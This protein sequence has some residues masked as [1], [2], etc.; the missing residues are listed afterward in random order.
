MNRVMIS[1]QAETVAALLPKLMRT[2][3]AGGDDAAARLPL[4]QLRVCGVLCDGPQPMSVVSRELGVSLPA[5]TQIADRLERVRLVERVS[6]G[7]DRRVRCLQLTDRGE[8]M[9]R[10][11]EQSRVAS[12]LAA[13][14][15]LTPGRRKAVVDML[16]LLIEAG[17]VVREKGGKSRRKAASGKRQ[18]PT[19]VRCASSRKSKVS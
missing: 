9:M 18:L 8:A 3:F 4:A 16:N 5:M 13:L 1:R 15:E 7:E 12:V 11:R 2:L 17:V 19:G 10:R 14:E 6:N